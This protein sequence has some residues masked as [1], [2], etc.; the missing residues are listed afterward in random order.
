MVLPLPKTSHI[1]QLSMNS[2]GQ[3]DMHEGPFVSEQFGLERQ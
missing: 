1:C 3:S 2:C